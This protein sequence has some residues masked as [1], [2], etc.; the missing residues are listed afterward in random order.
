MASL[1][2]LDSGRDMFRDDRPT[3]E[4]GYPS[5]MDDDIAEPVSPCSPLTSAVIR[6]SKAAKSGVAVVHRVSLRKF[7][8]AAE[9]R[10]PVKRLITR[11]ITSDSLASDIDEENKLSARGV[12]ITDGPATM[13]SPCAGSVR[14]PRPVSAGTVVREVGSQEMV[15]RNRDAVDWFRAS[16]AINRNIRSIEDTETLLEQA[17]ERRANGTT[18]SSRR[19]SKEIPLGRQQESAVA[20]APK[21]EEKVVKRRSFDA[22]AL[23]GAK[24]IKKEEPKPEPKPAGTPKNEKKNSC[25]RGDVQVGE[26][27]ENGLLARLKR[28]STIN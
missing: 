5:G 20:A 11:R 4:G 24:P 19:P 26:T 3:K 25:M 12:K 2:L 18:A 14:P 28:R 1:T 16:R 8:E 9:S 15:K 7:D 21:A 27:G 23:W 10:E 6:S 13:A 17:R 22:A